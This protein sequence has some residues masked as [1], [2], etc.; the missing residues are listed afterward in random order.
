[1]FLRDHVQKTGTDIRGLATT[2]TGQTGAKK[3]VELHLT[4]LRDGNGALTNLIVAFIDITDK[5]QTQHEILEN[6]TRYAN[7][8]RELQEK[9]NQLKALNEQHQK[10]SEKLEQMIHL[11][12][13][14]MHCRDSGQIFD[15]LAQAGERLLSAAGSAVFLMDDSRTVSEATVPLAC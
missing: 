1:M 14:M 8:N 6:Q 3:I 15:L 10:F 13:E 9:S 5:I 7:V 12:N 2:V 11:G 4:I